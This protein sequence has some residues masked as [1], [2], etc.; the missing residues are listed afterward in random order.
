MDSP[1]LDPLD[2]DLDSPILDPLDLDLDPH[3]LADPDPGYLL[4]GENGNFLHN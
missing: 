2:P 3:F 1:I 4:R